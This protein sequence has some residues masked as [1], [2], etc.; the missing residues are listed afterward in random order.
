MRTIIG[1]VLVCFLAF[2]PRARAQEADVLGW[3][4]ADITQGDETEAFYAHFD[5]NA[6]GAARFRFTIPVVRMYEI[7][8]GSYRLNGTELTL[9]SLGVSFTILDGGQAFEGVFPATFVSGLEVPVRFVRSAPP[10]APF[11]PPSPLGPPPSPTW[12]ASVGA[13]VWAG[14]VLDGRRALFV[15]DADGKLTA[16]S[17]QTGAQLWQADLGSTIRATPTLRG[18]RLYV[19]SDA[20][21]VTL[22]ARNGRQIWSAPFGAERSPRLAVT[23]EDSKWDHYSSSAAVDG[24]L[25]VVGSRDGCVY[26]I[27]VRTG[28]VRWRMRTQDIVTSTPALTSDAVYFGGFDGNAYALSRADGS[29]L[30]SYDTHGAIPRDV[31]VAGDTV[32]YG[33]RSYDVF[34]LNAHTG[35]PAWVRHVWYSWIDSPPVAA[36]GRIY[37]GASDALAVFAFNTTTGARIWQT[38]VP[39]WTWGGVALGLDN[40]YTG[41]VG[42]RYSA[43]RAGGFAAIRSSDG[44]LRWILG[45]EHRADPD[46]FYGFAAAPSV[47]GRRVFAANLDGTVYAFDDQGS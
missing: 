42:G 24:S 31:V 1:L 25:A 35:E 40:V 36:N 27:D 16:L 10:P 29:Q 47:L 32:L 26:A 14:L 4:R 15:A 43:P 20:A 34:A 21:L 45:S 3:W 30:W 2:V 19:A 28:A 5:Q 22:D 44:A 37:T 13:E 17:P 7:A 38:P 12:T 41:I 46:A 39:G 8:G 18:R 9:P 6:E 23:S 33:S 11:D